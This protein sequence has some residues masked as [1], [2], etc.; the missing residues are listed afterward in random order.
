MHTILHFHMIFEAWNVNPMQQEWKPTNQLTLCKSRSQSSKSWSIFIK[1]ETGVQ[2]Q[3]LPFYWTLCAMGVS[4]YVGVRVYSK[5][6]FHHLMVGLNYVIKAFLHGTED[7]TQQ[8][9]QL[10]RISFVSSQWHPFCTFIPL[11][12]MS[13][14]CEHVCFLLHLHSFPFTLLRSCWMPSLSK[15]HVFVSH[16]VLSYY[17]SSVEQL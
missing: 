1:H 3:S 6:S 4:M 11:V 16:L 8:A 10:V 15:W 12:V 2:P 5:W 9:A 7:E 14:L 13:Q 17:L